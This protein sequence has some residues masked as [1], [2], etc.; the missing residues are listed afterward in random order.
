VES[1]FCISSKRQKKKTKNARHRG[2]D[3]L[4]TLNDRDLRYRIQAVREK[5]GGGG[6]V[7]GVRGFKHRMCVCPVTP[8]AT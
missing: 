3:F 4:K 8:L 1:G 2:V 7:W 5:G 6:C